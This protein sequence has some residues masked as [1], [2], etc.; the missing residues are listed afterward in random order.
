VPELTGTPMPAAVILNDTDLTFAA[1][2]FD[3]LSWQS[4]VTC[5]MEIGDPLAESV[6]WG[7]AWDLVRT[8]ELDAAEFA[9]L[10]AR[11]I[12]TGRPLI[13][14]EQ[15]L[16]RALTGADYYTTP[17]ERPAA[18]R[19]LA[20][21]ALA[22]AERAQP[23]SR[24]QRILARGYATCA[25][26]SAQLDLL[27]FWLGSRSLPP[28]LVVDLGLRARILP[29]LAARDLAT[30]D[31]LA[32]YAADDPVA[33]DIRTATWQAMRPVS[34]A[35]EAAWAA[36][37]APGQSRRR[38]LAHAQGIWVP[39]QERLLGEFRER[40]FAEALTALSQQDTETAQRLARA[41][42]PATLA[43]DATLAATDAALATMDLAA[44]VRAILAEQRNLL[45]REITARARFASAAPG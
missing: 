7:A 20:A 27:R 9:A 25:D 43:D 2:R 10:V 13:E 5:A 8:A 17:G 1:I 15:L 39:G 45:Q 19:Q 23:G 35:K 11:R 29:T 37:L 41:L 12:T 4:I 36:A 30:D 21:A 26:S 34:A 14:L 44:P 38:A 3:P 28:G 6:C 18:R 16:G 40:Y 42:Y 24:G 22:A 33:A 31:D 32:A